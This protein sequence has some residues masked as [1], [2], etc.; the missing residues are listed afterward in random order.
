MASGT[1]KWYLRSKGL[2]L[3][4]SDEDGGFVFLHHSKM[5]GNTN[6]PES[7]KGRKISFETEA[8]IRGPIAINAQVLPKPE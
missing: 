6:F 5:L 1:I 8:G 7:I 2:G 3:I 4:E